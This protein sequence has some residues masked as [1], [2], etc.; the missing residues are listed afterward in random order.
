MNNN[1]KKYRMQKGFTLA[2]LAKKTDLSAGYLCH[3]EN[4][5]RLNPSHN[6]MVKISNA[7]NI[8]VEDI[9]FH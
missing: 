4:G 6:S 9:F 2:Q 8:S 1:L 5:G 3:L 7:L